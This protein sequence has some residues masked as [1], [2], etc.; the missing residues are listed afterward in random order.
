MGITTVGKAGLSNLCGGVSSPLAFTKLA[1][2]TG[3]TA[4]SAAD[5]ALGTEETGSGL[6][7]ATS[8]NTQ[9][10]TTTTNDTTQATYT[11]SVSGT[12]TI[13]EVGFLDTTATPVLLAR[14][15]LSSSRS[16]VNGDSFT[17]TAKI[18]FA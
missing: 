3:T 7:K 16:V 4:F 10:T 17:L 12:V 8:T 9:I 6:A 18:K 1:V 11:W 15:V 2:G 14:Q 13:A 5:T